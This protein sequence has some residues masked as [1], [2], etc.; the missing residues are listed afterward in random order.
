LRYLSI[1]GERVSVIGLGAWQFG[2][3][4][5][6]WNEASR[7]EALRIVERALELGVNLIDTAEIYGWGRSEEILGEALSG[8]REKAWLASK[9]FPILP[10]PGRL[11]AAA[12]ASLGRLK[13]DRL[14]LYQLHFDNPVVPLS[15]QMR[16]LG[17][18]QTDGLIRHVGVS[19]YSLK[20]WKKAEEALGGPVA[21]NQVEYH[22]LKRNAE[23]MLEWARANGRLVIAYSPL[24]QGLLSGRYSAENVP[25]DVRRFN[26]FFSRKKI[27]R[28]ARVLDA[29]RDIGAR[30]GATRAQ[31]ALAWVIRGGNVAAI[32]GAKTVRQLEEN[33][34]AADL[35]L[36]ADETARLDD[37]SARFVLPD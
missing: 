4:E 36:S 25:A 33:A 32:P 29:L 30:H 8:R 28:A 31:V 1:G 35:T 15:I 5:W 26:P 21:A 12:R 22:L 11:R 7:A 34:A 3:R 9:V 27:S 18:L 24:A 2:A 6:N 14:D 13:T 37:A 10:L 23:V 16:G 17:K 20:R 19:N